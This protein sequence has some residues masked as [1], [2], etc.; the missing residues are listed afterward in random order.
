[1]YPARSAARQAVSTVADT[2]ISCQV[3]ERENSCLS[4]IIAPEMTPVSYPNRKPPMAER[5]VRR[6]SR[7]GTLDW[8]LLT[9]TAVTA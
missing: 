6:R 5:K 3:W 4:R 8:G 7:S 2:I 9:V 1:M